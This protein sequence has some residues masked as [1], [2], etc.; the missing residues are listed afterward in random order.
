MPMKAADAR[1]SSRYSMEREELVA[2]HDRA[3][4]EHYAQWVTEMTGVR[5]RRKAFTQDLLDGTALCS[6]VARV[7]DSGVKSYKD[8]RQSPAHMRAFH[9]RDNMVKFQDAC[10]RLALPDSLSTAD[11]ESGNVRKALSIMVH[12]EELCE[13][14]E[15]AP[16][17]A[18]DD[19]YDSAAD[20][21]DEVMVEQEIEEDEVVAEPPSVQP[22]ETK[23]RSSSSS[24][25]RSSRLSKRSSRRGSK[26]EEEDPL[27]AML[28]RFKDFCGCDRFKTSD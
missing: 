9:A 5:V 8:V 25:R 3:L 18:P 14:E 27:Q 4:L 16:I 11:L 13:D 26:Q 15:L 22:S 1:K 20:D 10:R 6:I 21:V 7:P 28:G 2:L 23:R 24:R 17:G 19:G 12:L